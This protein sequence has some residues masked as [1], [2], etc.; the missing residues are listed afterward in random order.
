MNSN[1]Q[2]AAANAAATNVPPEHAIFKT[3]VGVPKILA[4]Q[5]PVDFANFINLG[6]D[7]EREN[8]FIW[9]CLINMKKCRTRTNHL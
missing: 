7:A 6:E 3:S 2:P 8:S 4:T 5:R 9:C 1:T